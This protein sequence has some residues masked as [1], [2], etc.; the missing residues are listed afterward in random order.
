MKLNFQKRILFW[1]KWWIT[2]SVEQ[3]DLTLKDWA[4][5]AAWSNS[6]FWIHLVHKWCSSNQPKFFPHLCSSPTFKPHLYLKRSIFI[7]IAS[8]NSFIFSEISYVKPKLLADLTE[9]Q[10]LNPEET[11]QLLFYKLKAPKLTAV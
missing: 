5:L 11:N 3:K 7:D 10:S 9:T 8:A 1:H 2:E 6:T 4:A